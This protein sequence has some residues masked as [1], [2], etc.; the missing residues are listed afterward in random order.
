MHYLRYT[1][2]NEYPY[3]Y[4]MDNPMIRYYIGHTKIMTEYSDG[5]TIA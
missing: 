4:M 1:G 3:E 5:F 2:A